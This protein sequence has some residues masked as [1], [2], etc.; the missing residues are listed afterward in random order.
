MKLLLAEDEARMAETLSELLL[1]EQYEVDVYMDGSSGLEAAEQNVYDIL[2]LDVMLPDL[3]GFALAKA[4][5][6]TGITPIL[7]LT[8]KS[9]ADNKVTEL[10]SVADDYLTKPFS[11]HCSFV[12]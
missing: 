6:K 12:K 8:A 4:V 5:S 11:S 3:S 1:L 2:I 7:M 10:D 9:S